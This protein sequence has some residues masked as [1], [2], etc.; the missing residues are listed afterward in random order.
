MTRSANDTVSLGPAARVMA[1]SAM[2]TEG[3]RSPSAPIHSKVLIA[4]FPW[5]RSYRRELRN[6]RRLHGDGDRVAPGIV[7]RGPPRGFGVPLE[8]V[9]LGGRPSVD[10]A[11]HRALPSRRVGGH[12]AGDDGIAPHPVAV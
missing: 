10:P 5:R 1:A 4:A 6:R 3:S 2:A 11:Q 9:R 7:D 8:V 12:E